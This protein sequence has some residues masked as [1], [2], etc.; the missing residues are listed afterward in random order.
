MQKTKRVYYLTG[1]MPAIASLAL[2]RLKV[3]R[4]SDLN[5]PFELLGVNL[6]DRAVRKAFRATRDQLNENQGLVCFTRDWKNP[7]MWGHYAEKHTGMALGFDVPRDMLT[8]V[9]YAE[10]LFDLKL[11]PVTKRPQKGTVDKLIATKFRDWKYENEF[12]LFVQLDHDEAEGG[13]YFVPFSE[14]LRLREVVLGPRCAYVSA[15]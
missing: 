9:T 1:C 10:K 11:D 8:E 6:G 5:D 15:R 12:R 7:L 4:F 3:S 2:G 13:L 14:N